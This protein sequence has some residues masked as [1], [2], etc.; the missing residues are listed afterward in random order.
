MTSFRQLMSAADPGMKIIVKPDAVQCALL[1]FP[2]HD[3]NLVSNRE[4]LCFYTPVVTPGW[5]I[6]I[7]GHVWS[8]FPVWSDGQVRPSTFQL[9]NLAIGDLGRL[10]D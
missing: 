9:L 6:T 10:Q 3:G 1:E 8:L 4:S 5:S 7:E 2:S